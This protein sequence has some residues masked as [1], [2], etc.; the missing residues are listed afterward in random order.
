MLHSLR[1]VFVDILLCPSFIRCLVS[2]CG[3][4]CPK[5]AIF[6]L[7]FYLPDSSS[8]RTSHTPEDTLC[9]FPLKKK[10]VTHPNVPGRSAASEGAMV[11]GPWRCH[12][13]P[14]PAALR[15]QVA[16]HSTRFVCVW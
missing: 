3:C 12:A 2:S 9:L 14:V 15:P 7:N 11:A 10:T 6:Q 1:I 5:G 16:L 4:L 13:R 8:H